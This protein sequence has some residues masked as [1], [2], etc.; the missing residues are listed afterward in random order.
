MG[1]LQLDYF[2]RGFVTVKVSAPPQQV[3]NGVVYFQ[4]TEGRLAA[5][6]VE[7]NRFFSSNNIMRELPYVKS[8]ENGKRILNSKVFQTELD[9]AN[10]NPDCQIAPEVRPGFG[11]GTTALIL[12]VNDR[13]PLHGPLDFDN[14]SPPG[15][16]QLRVNANASYGNLWQLDHSLGLQY[17]FSPDLL[18]PSMD[19]TH[20]SLYPIDAPNVTYYSGYYRAPRER[21]K[22]PRTRLPRTQ[23]ILATTKRL[24]SLS[25]PRPPDGRI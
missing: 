22:R 9:R 1:V 24:N 17:G 13:L 4:V 6:K 10:S 15:T 16:P 19:G 21:R 8:L 11:P 20:I 25:L 7:H 14:Y 2:Q 5:V 23:T 12:D 3:T 18:K